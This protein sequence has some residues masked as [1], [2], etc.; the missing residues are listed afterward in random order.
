MSAILA[1]SPL[2]IR[3]VAESDFPVLN[4]FLAGEDWMPGKHDVECFFL[5][6]KEGFFCGEIQN[7]RGDK[8][9][10]GFVVALKF[11]SH[12][13]FVSDFVVAKQY[14][15]QGYGKQLWASAMEHIK[16]IQLRRSA[17]RP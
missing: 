12:Y 8:E 17:R 2:T 16:G 6:D 3:Q 10:V 5:T 15:G 4:A 14:R 7:D 1:P 13:A 11:T 9:T